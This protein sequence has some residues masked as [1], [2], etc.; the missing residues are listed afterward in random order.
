[1]KPGN[2]E[3]FEW[4]IN[5][6][7]AAKSAK[8]NYSISWLP[9]NI[10][11]LNGENLIEINYAS[12]SSKILFGYSSERE[13]TK[14]V[15]YIDRFD[16]NIRGEGGLIIKNIKSLVKK[17]I[18]PLANNVLLCFPLY[19]DGKIYLENIQ[20]IASKL[21]IDSR[22]QRYYI[23]KLRQVYSDSDI[24]KHDR[25]IK[26]DLTSLR[27]WLHSLLMFND[28]ALLRMLNK[29]P[30]ETLHHWEEDDFHVVSNR[31]KKTAT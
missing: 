11:G 3:K 14:T 13:N 4:L 2:K 1:M 17:T 23:K 8:N 9:Y 18:R 31:C 19:R 25:D 26:K 29:N 21:K 28:D 6:I 15:L 30:D 5:S 12:D 20:F 16:P 24:G 10:K 27:H 7:I 22:E